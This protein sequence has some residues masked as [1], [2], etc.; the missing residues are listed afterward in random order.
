MKSIFSNV[1]FDNLSV[2]HHSGILLAE[3]TYY[4]FGLAM[5]GISA[6]AALKPQHKLK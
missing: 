4:P 1:D 5:S 3:N 6:T 2:T